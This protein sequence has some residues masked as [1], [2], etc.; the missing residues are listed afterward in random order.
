MKQKTSPR[1]P[2]DALLVTTASL[3]PLHLPLMD[4]MIQ[5]AHA[6]RAHGVKKA[7]HG[8]QTALRAPLGIL[9]SYLLKLVVLIVTLVSSAWWKA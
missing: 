4:L 3:G 1:Q 8:P 6:L 7:G 9:I 2:T 5:E